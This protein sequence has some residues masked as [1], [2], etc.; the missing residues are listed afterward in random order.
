MCP[1]FQ[2][3]CRGCPLLT[4]CHPY[5]GLL[6]WAGWHRWRDCP[7]KT[8]AMTQSC[9][10][11][12]EVASRGEGLS[13]VWNTSASTVLGMGGPRGTCVQEKA[14]SSS[15]GGHC[16]LRSLQGPHHQAAWSERGRAAWVPAIGRVALTRA[17]AMPSAVTRLEQLRA[18]HS[19]ACVQTSCLELSAPGRHLALRS[20]S[21]LAPVFLLPGKLHPASKA[22]GAISPIRARRSRPSLAGHCCGPPA[23]WA[24]GH[25][26]G[27]GWGQAHRRGSLSFP[28]APLS[29]K[30]AQHL[31]G[32]TSHVLGWSQGQNALQRVWGHSGG[33]LWQPQALEGLC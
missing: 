2:S 4:P 6:P 26:T 7:M 29:A 28:K 3:A 10:C 30:A 15:V 16:A 31:L 11:Q 18:Q 8:G 14:S 32:F 1:G 25:R 24:P 23:L 33:L 22:G 12:P 13:S 19:S 21:P 17:S 27:D 20:D 5:A 9:P